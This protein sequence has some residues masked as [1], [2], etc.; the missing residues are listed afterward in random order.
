M[1][2]VRIL[3]ADD[4]PVFREGLISVF[5]HQPE[6][7]VAGE[8]RDGHQALAMMQNIQPDVLLLDLIMPG[9]TGLETLR[10]MSSPAIPTRTILLTASIAKEQIAQALQ[11]GARGIVLK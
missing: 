11:L 7:A 4:H 6:F 3:I 1:Q 8:A 10:E 2:P 9:L 5:R